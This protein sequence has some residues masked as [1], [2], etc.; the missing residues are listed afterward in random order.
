LSENILKKMGALALPMAGAMGGAFL[1]G[2][3]AGPAGV[4]PGWLGG[5]YAGGKAS[6]KLFPKEVLNMSKKKMKAR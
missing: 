5:K 4:L 6:E 2:A 3:T 1:G